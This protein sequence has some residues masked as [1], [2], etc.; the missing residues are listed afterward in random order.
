MQCELFVL[1]DIEV[2]TLGYVIIWC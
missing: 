2:I 1:E